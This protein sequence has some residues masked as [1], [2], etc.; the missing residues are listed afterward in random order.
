MNE[1]EFKPGDIIIIIND[2]NPGSLKSWFYE[3]FGV[4]IGKKAICIGINDKYKCNDDIIRTR[5]AIEFLDDD[6]LTNI[7]SRLVLAMHIEKE[8]EL[9][10]NEYV[11]ERLK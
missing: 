11:K 3:G 9:T 4:I 2:T 6:K 5:Y 1:Q 10:L 7:K 8:T